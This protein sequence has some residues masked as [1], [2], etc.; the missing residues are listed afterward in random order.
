MTEGTELGVGL[1]REIVVEKLKITR[2]KKDYSWY[3]TLWNTNYVLRC[4][5]N[6]LN[7]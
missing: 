6:L 1:I 5:P 4:F 7:D 2:R 3:T